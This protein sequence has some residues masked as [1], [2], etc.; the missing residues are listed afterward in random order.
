MLSLSICINVYI[1]IVTIKLGRATA[2]AVSRWPHCRGRFLSEF[3]GFS[4]CSLVFLCQHHSTV[5]LCTQK[6]FWGMKNRPV[7]GHSSDSLFHPTDMNSNNRVVPNGPRKD[8]KVNKMN[9][10]FNWHQA[11]T[12]HEVRK[13][14]VSEWGFLNLSYK[15]GSQCSHNKPT[16]ASR[17]VCHSI[18]FFTKPFI[19]ETI[20]TA[21]AWAVF[22]YQ[23]LII[24]DYHASCHMF[25]SKT[26]SA[27]WFDVLK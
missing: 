23:V 25:T 8:S 2:E 27:S 13:I 19:S 10:F 17:F 20:D 18:L 7:G 1:F 12:R 15:W 5:P 16:V 24:C 14:N 21:L 26:H 9:M 3:F 11:G 6:N 4:L 22:Q